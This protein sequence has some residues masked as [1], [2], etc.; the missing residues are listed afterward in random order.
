MVAFITIMCLVGLLPISCYREP[1]GTQ[2]LCFV[3]WCPILFWWIQNF[4]IFYS[5]SVL[6]FVDGVC[7]NPLYLTVL[8]Q[9]CSAILDLDVPHIFDDSGFKQSP[10]LCHAF[11]CAFAQDVVYSILWFLCYTECYKIKYKSYTKKKTRKLNKT[12]F[13]WTT[14]QTISQLSLDISCIWLPLLQVGSNCIT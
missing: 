6:F 13:I 11:P 5:D 12:A 2:Y 9:K 1:H 7:F 10:F 14:V 8:I 4:F 3:G